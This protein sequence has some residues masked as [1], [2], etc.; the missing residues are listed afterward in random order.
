[1]NLEDGSP[2]VTSA[3]RAAQGPGMQTI[4]IPRD[5][6]FLI[7]SYPGSQILGIPA[8]LTKAIDLP[9]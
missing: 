1:M 8:S 2:L 6:A 5:L 7:S 9:V 4:F 3:V